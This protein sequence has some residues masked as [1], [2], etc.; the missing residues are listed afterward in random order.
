MF[1]DYAAG[2]GKPVVIRRDDDYLDEGDWP[3]AYVGPPLPAVE[4]D[5][6]G[7]LRGRVLDVG[8][9]PG[10][11]LLWLQGCGVEAVGID[12]SPGTVEVA[13]QRGC[14]QVQVMAV[15][16]LE[17][18]AGSFDGVILLGNN[19]GLAGTVA[20]TEGLLRHLSGLV[21]PGGLLIGQTRDPLATQNPAHL[22]YH[23][24]NRRRGLP[25]GQVRI[26][27]EYDGLV[28]EWLD[29]LMLQPGALTDLLDRTG[30]EV[31]ELVP[32]PGDGTVYAVARRRALEA[33]DR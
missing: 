32:C 16:A 4:E 28:G 27:L 1:G 20:A 29:L 6:L 21:R 22:A 17:F 24:A 26:R 13:R 5:L 12:Y 9:G 25:P 18:P 31:E 10:R 3:G 23:E 15:T 7:R 8:C 14:R 2:R 11:H 19:V 33:L 30:W